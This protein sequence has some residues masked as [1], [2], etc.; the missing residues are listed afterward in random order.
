MAVAK[1]SKAAVA[2]KAMKAMSTMKAAT[3]MKAAKP[4][5][6]AMK[7]P[8]KSILARGALM[9][10][11]VLAGRKEKTYTGHKASDLTKNRRGKIVTKVNSAAARKRYEGSKLQKWIQAVGIARKQL[12]IKGYVSMNSPTPEGRAFYAKARAIYTA[13]A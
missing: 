8:M 11:A 2:T 1:G 12:G 7:K 6:I 5:K 13:Q 10:A 9:R 4:M 3:A